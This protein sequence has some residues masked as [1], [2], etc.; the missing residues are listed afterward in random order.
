MGHLVAVTVLW[1]F[2]FS[3]I[4]VYLAGHVDVYFAVLTRITLALAL[5]APLLRPLATRPRCALGLMLIGAFQIGLMYLFFY[6]S[7]L[8][9]SVPEVLLFS[10]VTPVYITLLDDLLERRF[11]PRY[12][13]VA[14]LAVAGA[15]LIRYTEVGEQVWLGFALMQGANLCFAIGQVAYRRLEPRLARGV[16][17]YRQFGW[18]FAGAWPVAALSFMVFGDRSALPHTAVQWGVLLW[19]GMAASGVGYYAW[20]RGTARV[21]AGTLAVMNN[22]LIPAGLAVNLVIWNHDADLLRLLAGALIIGAALT[23]NQVWARPEPAKT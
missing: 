9:I 21:D 13:L 18:F 19:L 16:P 15:G 1:A 3:L 14:V 20:N 17:V 11:A 22:M 12:L 5:F 2:S 23:L 10:I 6:N 7:F 4:G 8:F